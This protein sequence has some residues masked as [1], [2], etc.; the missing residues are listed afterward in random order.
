MMHPQERLIPSL[1]VGLLLPTLNSV[2]TSC[3]VRPS[4][5]VLIAVQHERSFL[6]PPSIPSPSH[7]LCIAPESSTLGREGLLVV[8]I[9][10]ER[11]GVLS[12]RGEVDRCWSCEDILA[13]SV[14]EKG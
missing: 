2:L 11:E 9:Q 7:S 4:S 6:L 14:E 5:I 10:V 13:G 1:G 12:R 8:Q 3:S